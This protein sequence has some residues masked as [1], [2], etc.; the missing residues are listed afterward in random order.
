[1]EMADD[2]EV[3]FEVEPTKKELSALDKKSKKDQ[4]LKRKLEEE[5]KEVKRAKFHVNDLTSEVALLSGEEQAK[6]VMKEF[7]F[8]KEKVSALTLEKEQELKGAEKERD[9]LFFSQPK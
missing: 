6:Y 9:S 8:L 1:V 2:L 4:K 7:A 5:R 3:N